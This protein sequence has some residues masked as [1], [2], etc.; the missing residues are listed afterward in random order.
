MV[1]TVSVEVRGQPPFDSTKHEDYWKAAEAA[2]L[3]F[4]VL[5]KA[6]LNVRTVAIKRGTDVVA[7]TEDGHIMEVYTPRE[8]N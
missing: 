1:Y 5:D 6:G 8:I 2:F 4:K 7:C 3:T